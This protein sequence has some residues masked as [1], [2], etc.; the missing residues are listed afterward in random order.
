MQSFLFRP[1]ESRTGREARSLS[2]LD[3]Y[4]EGV[5][6]TESNVRQIVSPPTSPRSWGCLAHEGRKS[7][8]QMLWRSKAML[9]SPRMGRSNKIGSDESDGAE[10]L[11]RA[12]FVSL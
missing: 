2:E 10:G 6:S 9:Y 1:D 12:E 4:N 7:W 5:G 8:C 11:I 3:G